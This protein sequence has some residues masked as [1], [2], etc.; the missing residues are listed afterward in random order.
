[1]KKLLLLLII[2]FLSAQ[3]FAAGCPD[4][5]E[6]IKSVSADGTYFVFNCGGGSE[7]ASSSSSNASNA[8][9]SE[10][11]KVAMK[12]DRGD[13]I[14]SD[15]SGG[16]PM[17]SA[18]DVKHQMIHNPKFA[19]Y[20][21]VC[22]VAYGDY[23]NDGVDDLFVVVAPHVAGMTFENAGM[24]CNVGDKSKCYSQAGTVVVFKVK[25]RKTGW[26]DD[27]IES[28]DDWTSAKY[29]ARE[30]SHLLFNS[31]P[32]DM[33]GQGS[34]R[35]VLMDFNGDGKLDIMV[36][37]NGWWVDGKVPGKNDVYYLSNEGEG[38]TESSVTH[39]TGETVQKGR[40]LKIFS[41][42]LT[43]GDIDGDGDID[44]VVTSVKW[45]GRNQSQNG[46]IFCYINQ[47]DGHMV[48]RKCGDQFGFEVELGDIDNDGDLDLVFGS[49]TYA[50]SDFW[51]INNRTP[52]CYSKTKCN[53]AF[54]GI[55]LNDGDGNF[56][57]R[58]F[59]FDDE[60]LLSTGIPTYVVPN[61]SVA[62]LDGDGDL[63][64]VRSLVG[65]EYSGSIM[66]IEENLGD[67]TFKTAYY[68]E[69]C[70]GAKT[71]ADLQ[72][73]EGDSQ[74]CWN[75]EFKFGD[76]NNDGL[77]D[78]YIDGTAAGKVEW[79]RDGAI[80]MSTGK[81]TYDIIQTRDEDYPLIEL[82]IKKSRTKLK[83]V[84]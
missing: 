4:G 12:P 5:S 39:I 75:S 82:E 69:H 55:L 81:F 48:V 41:H 71:K 10:K 30:E 73:W 68:S 11:V 18:H 53:G 51:D 7:Q 84:Y 72:E 22:C 25:Q 62:D 8:N 77:V 21:D 61:I 59:A 70:A 42:S 44:A 3:S 79:L 27:G 17:W 60:V 66:T 47:G 54:N 74:N 20:M 45:V 36:N 64:V 9:S 15:N 6:P 38:W 43:A 32:L 80:Y 2:S 65:L 56:F 14:S 1:M 37:D 33:A 13:W 31:N 46:E 83:T 49:N 57:E 19:K 26:V 23:D 24:M 78:I 50:G 63:D 76:F 67:G 52:G 28:T 35:I 29:T 34:A 16:L 58:G 40:G